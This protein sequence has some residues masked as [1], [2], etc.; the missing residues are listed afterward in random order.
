MKVGVVFE[1]GG[2]RG[3]YTAGVI[4]AFLE[5][6]F[7]PDY[8]VG[9]SAGASNGASYLSKQRGRALR[10]N[11]DYTDEPRYASLKSWIKTGSYF[12]MDFLFGEIP[13]HYDPYDWDAC[14]A[15]PCAFKIG[16]T[17]IETGLPHF[18]DKSDLDERFTVIRA[19]C[20][21]PL[22]SRPIEWQGHIYLDGG[23]TRPIPFEEA[24]ADGCDFLV[25]VL[26]QPRGYRKSPQKGLHIM[27]Q[28]LGHYPA[29]I[30]AMSLRHEVYNRELA[31]LSAL[32]QAGKAFVLAPGEELKLDRMEKDGNRLKAAGRQGY[33][34]GLDALDTLRPLLADR[35]WRL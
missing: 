8:V 11:I 35:Q 22:F 13:Q 12:G 7:M 3:V 15:N 10:C 28:A 25:V 21:M 26:T 32:E 19:S 14:R 20:S 16:T 23:V 29:L 6:D 1:G 18:F 24:L 4:E 31:E 33:L 27:E 30:E 9:V 17:D 5:R 34:D 2:M